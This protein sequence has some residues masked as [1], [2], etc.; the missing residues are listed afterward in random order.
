[1]EVV[2]SRHCV[3]RKGWSTRL[4]LVLARSDR[5]ELERMED[6]LLLN[7]SFFFLG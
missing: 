6:S 3:K 4:G 5:I 7:I 2:E 1:M